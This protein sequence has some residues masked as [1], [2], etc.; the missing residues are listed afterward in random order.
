MHTLRCGRPRRK[1]SHFIP[2]TRFISGPKTDGP[3][4]TFLNYQGSLNFSYI[5]YTENFK[6]NQ[7]LRFIFKQ[8]SLLGFRFPS[9]IMMAYHNYKVLLGLILPRQNFDQLFQGSYTLEERAILPEDKS[10]HK[11]FFLNFSYIYYSEIFKKFQI[12][13][14]TLFEF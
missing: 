4:P 11:V 13:I 3:K 1:E 5:Y 7:I 14:T 12:L 9:F 6:E 8:Y 2:V 10:Y